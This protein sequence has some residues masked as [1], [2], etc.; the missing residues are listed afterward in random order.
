MAKLLV[1]P[2]FAGPATGLISDMY[3]IYFL[4]LLHCGPHVSYIS[5]SVPDGTF[6][7]DMLV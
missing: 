6:S 3:C 4:T 7:K 5:G 2:I 1:R